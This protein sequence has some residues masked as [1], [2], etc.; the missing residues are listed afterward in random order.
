MLVVAMFLTK[1][2]APHPTQNK[3]Q[4]MPPKGRAQTQGRAKAKAK[5]TL[6]R[7]KAKAKAKAQ[8]HSRV[9]R[10]VRRRQF[11]SANK[12]QALRRDAIRELN[13]LGKEL[14]SGALHVPV[15]TVLATDPRVERLVRALE[16]RCQTPELATRLRAAVLLW[17][18]N[19]GTL[20]RAVAPEAGAP[21]DAPPPEGEPDSAAEEQREPAPAIPKHRVLQPGYTLKSKAFMLTYNSENFSRGTWTAFCRCIKRWRRL[22]GARWW[23]ACL[24]E[25]VHAQAPARAGRYHL[26]AYL[27]WTDHVG[28][29]RRNLDDFRFE[30]VL[31]NVSQCKATGQINFP[32]AAAHGVWYVSLMKSG[33]I[34]SATNFH[35]WVDYS[36]QRAWLDSLY[37]QG[38]VSHARYKELSMHHPLGYANRKRD[39]AEVMRDEHEAAV[40]ALV[41]QEEAGLVTEPWRQFPEVDDFEAH[42]DPT[43]RHRRP[44]LAIVGGTQSGKSKLGCAILERIA[45][46]MGLQSYVEVTVEGDS[47]LDL[48]DF[49]VTKHSGVLL[50]G[51]GD[52]L[53]LKHN[54]EILQGRPKLIKGGRSSTMIYAYRYTLCRRAVIATFDLSATNLHLLS[55]D[56]WLKDRRNVIL[57]R[58]TA[59][60]WQMLGPAPAA[61]SPVEMMREWTSAEVSGFLRSADLA[62]PATACLASGV[63]GAD[64]LLLTREALRDDV[65]LTPFAARKVVVARD[66][67]LRGRQ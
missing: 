46:R 48:S 33:T 18:D 23:A 41:Q 67:F 6:G 61:R 40:T 14:L 4:T 24:E 15:K 19:A 5:T 51:V 62:G 47:E 52:A 54:R 22:L 2:C 35:A 57:L 39:I 44:V 12:R 10:R 30:D 65:R 3:R 50:D 43:P 16:P 56:H 32:T 11:A 27:Y 36:P 66:D 38:K 26:H 37:E 63:N 64:L 25:S 55:T 9:R 13:H 17:I 34:E 1:G 20:C 28:I 31:P 45:S 53:T 60:A 29:F 21:A 49:R 8:A 42:F 58:L 7:A 59:P